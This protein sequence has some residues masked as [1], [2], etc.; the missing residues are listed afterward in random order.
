MTPL[1]RGSIEA[2]FDAIA[3]WWLQFPLD[4]DHGGFAG[5]VD[6]SGQ[7]VDGAAKGVVLNSRILWFFSE[8][9][10]FRKDARCRARAD[11]AFLYLY[12][13]FHDSTENGAVW[14]LHA[15]GSIEQ[16]KKQIYAQCFCIYAF[17]AYY[18]ATGTPES[19]SRAFEYFDLVEKRARDRELGGYHEAFSRDW[20]PL[21]DVRLGDDDLNAPK[22]MNTHLHLLEAY[23]ALH[24]VAGNER[25][26]TALRDSIEI[27]CE[28]IV[29]REAGHLRLYFDKHWRD[30]SCS[31]SFGHDIEASWLLREAAEALEDDE[32]LE[33]T[34][35][36]SLQLAESCLS[37]GFGD[38]GQVCDE[39]NLHTRQRGA[40]S[41]W[42]VQAEALVGFL[43]AFELTRD[44]RFGAAAHQVWNHILAHHKDR[45]AGEWHWMTDSQGKPLP[46]Y[47]KA[48]FWKGP[49]HN[50]R[51]MLEASR[52]IERIDND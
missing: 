18:A 5:E 11:C 25:T 29:D 49:Y 32:L 12:D 2:E 30:L 31:W 28:R 35:A 48:G 34:C 40:Y 46:G 3:D 45:A 10:R 44:E 7:L 50:G 20:Q 24:K 37:A 26:A 15:D 16:A 38:L 33:N 43:N 21:A 9:N 1:N 51:A 27:F 13:H 47:C 22:T 52:L 41:V 6:F 36:I 19:L 17:S 42:W 8:L 39:Y 23:T 4:A 14:S